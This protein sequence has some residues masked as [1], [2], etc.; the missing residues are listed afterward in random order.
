M[1]D[2]HELTAGYALN[3]LAASDHARFEDHLATCERCREELQE[4]SHVAAAL[5]YAA[6]GPAPPASLRERI[7]EQ[8]RG[9]RPNV[10]PLRRRL[11]LPLVSSAAAVAAVAALAFGLWAS[12]LSSDLDDV[13]GKVALL[14]DP[15]ARTYDSENGEASLVVT[16]SGEAALLVRRLAP[17]PEG[18]DYEIWVF[19][20]QTPRP[21]GLFESPGIAL[22]SRRVEPGQRVAVTLEPDGGVAAPTGAPLFT[23]A[24]T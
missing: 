16:P 14:A 11:V 2:V 15:D 22:L 18:K 13:R 21:A 4:F 6:D 9:E 12:S 8:A 23:A 5:A 7:L 10:V 20:G 3:A 24:A 1:D 17:A 19:E